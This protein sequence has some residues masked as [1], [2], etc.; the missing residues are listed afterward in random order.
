MNAI[1]VPSGDHV[2]LVSRS[3]LGAMYFTVCVFTSYTA[4]KL[5]VVRLLTNATLVPS[6]DQRGPLFW[7]HALMNGTSPLSAFVICGVW[8]TRAR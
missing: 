1:R 6:G 5:C 3:T 2:G 4:M 7:P 8:L